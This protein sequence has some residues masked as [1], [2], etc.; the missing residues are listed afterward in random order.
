MGSNPITRFMVRL[1]KICD[2]HPT[3]R[4]LKQIHVHAA[5]LM[6]ALMT[7]PNFHVD[8]HGSSDGDDITYLNQKCL[9]YFKGKG[10]IPSHRLQNIHFFHI[11]DE[12]DYTTKHLS[13]TVTPPRQYRFR[14]VLGEVGLLRIINGTNGF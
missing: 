5:I 6:T 10:N 8:A 11:V 4:D 9:T 3:K 7:A 12:L 14:L 13:V 2:A 1:S